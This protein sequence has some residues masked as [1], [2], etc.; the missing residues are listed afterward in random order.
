VF[1]VDGLTC[2]K[3]NVPMVVLAFITDPPVV[4]RILDH[5]H[6]PSV[7][8]PVAP[9]RLRVDDNPSLA[10]ATD[11]YRDDWGPGGW[12]GIDEP[13]GSCAPRATRGSRPAPSPRA[14]PT[15]RRNEAHSCAPADTEP[16]PPC[17]PAAS[18]PR[19][20]AA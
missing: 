4:R 1:D 12:G 10:L 17:L 2:A 13:P 11:E 20:T 18:A 8:A 6:L 3:C 15:H 7:P 16:P 9:A 5:L 19:L 14:F